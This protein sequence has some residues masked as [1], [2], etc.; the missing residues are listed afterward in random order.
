MCQSKIPTE[1]DTFLIKQKNENAWQLAFK[2][3]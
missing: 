1:N 2:F 3:N